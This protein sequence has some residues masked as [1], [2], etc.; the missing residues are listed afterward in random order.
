M[1]MALVWLQGFAF[2]HYQSKVSNLSHMSGTVSIPITSKRVTD[3]HKILY[4]VTTAWNVTTGSQ[5]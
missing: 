2:L 1:K 3:Y 5:L 4:F